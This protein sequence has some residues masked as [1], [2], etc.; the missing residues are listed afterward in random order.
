[1]ARQAGAGLRR[2]GE[3]L[4]ST[5]LQRC[6]TERLINSRKTAAQRSFS[7]ALQTSA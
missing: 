5:D 7:R 4:H 6:R 2:T 1:M 3:R